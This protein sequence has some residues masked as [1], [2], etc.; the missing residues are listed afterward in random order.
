MK[1]ALM[2]NRI[3]GLLILSAL[4]TGCGGG[5]KK[6]S[7]KK[8]S[9]RVLEYTN[10]LEFLNDDGGVISTLRFVKADTPSE[11]NQGL[12]NVTDMPQ[13]AGM[14]FYFDF[15]GPQSFWMANT[16]LPL[17]IMYVSADSI[18]VSIYRNTIPFS[19]TTLPSAAP[20]KYVIETNAGY[21]IN[22][23]IQ[24]GTKVRF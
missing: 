14:V 23:D 12:M 8:Q 13:D 16:P 15:E 21:S 6:N 24:E 20:A 2:L 22:Y 7:G 5:E 4:L 1:S 18:I 3:I 9:G 10:T 11:R 17:D 19:E